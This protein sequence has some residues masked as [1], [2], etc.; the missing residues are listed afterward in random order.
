MA[1]NQRKRMASRRKNAKRKET[2]QWAVGTTL[3]LAVILFM[4]FRPKSVPQLS[5]EYQLQPRGEGLGTLI[6]VSTSDHI[7]NGDP[8]DTPTDP[9][10]S[11]SHYVVPMPAGFYTINSPEYLDPNHDGHLIHSMEHGY[12]IFWYNCA[13]LSSSDCDTLLGEIQT[14]MDQFDGQKVIAFPRPTLEKPLVMT[15]WG[16]IQEFDTFDADFAVRFIETNQ[17]LAPEPNAM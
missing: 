16:Y 2:I 15:S 13:L 3:V 1:T 17:P 8:V 4:I 6:P 9:P 10:T 12:V 7:P 11:G 14:V 5:T